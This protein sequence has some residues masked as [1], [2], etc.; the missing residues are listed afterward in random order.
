M[1]LTLIDYGT[2]NLFSVRRALEVCGANIRVIHHPNEAKNSD[3]LVVPGVGAF[4]SCITELHR[5]HFNDAIKE[6][7]ATDRPFLGICVGMQMLMTTS[8][9]FGQH[10]GL[11][12]IPGTVQE[13]PNRT[14]SGEVRKR[15]HIGWT[16]LSEGQPWS[17][18]ILSQTTKDDRFYFVHSFS[19]VPDN[20]AHIL[21][22]TDYDGHEIVAAV[23]K[24]NIFGTQFH[25]EKSGPAGLAILKQFLSL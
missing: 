5:L 8:Y 4:G 23:K 25:P 18:T 9:E 16:S 6:H 17:N 10:S 20:P 24:D 15:P 13:I 1:N 19:V 14:D 7:I 3:R 21:A 12:L 2:G 11:N 22:L